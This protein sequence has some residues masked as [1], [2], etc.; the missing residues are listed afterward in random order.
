MK[1][2][3]ISLLNSAIFLTYSVG[4]YYIVNQT[5][6]HNPGSLTKLVYSVIL[7]LPVIWLI[8]FNFSTFVS[9][10]ATPMWYI[11]MILGVACFLFG[12]FLLMS[13]L[14][15][16][17]TVTVGRGI[18]VIAISILVLSILYDMFRYIGINVDVRSNKRNLLL[19]IIKLVFYIPCIFRGILHFIHNEIEIT[20]RPILTVFVL[21][22]CLLLVII[23]YTALLREIVIHPSEGG[24]I[25]VNEPVYLNQQI[26]RSLSS[27][28]KKIKVD[29]SSALSYPLRFSVSCWVFMNHHGSNYLAYAKDS[30]IFRLGKTSSQKRSVPGLFFRNMDATGDLGSIGS[31]V[32]KYDGSAKGSIGEI[33]LQVPL[34]RWT[35]FVF[36]YSDINVFDLFVDG[37]LVESR[38]IS[39]P[40]VFDDFDNFVVGESNGLDGS[41]CN[42]I[43]SPYALS[44]RNIQTQ[45]ALLKDE[46]P[47][48]TQ[49]SK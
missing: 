43:Y 24:I 45:Y 5:L 12:I 19:L 9:L 8:Y 26:I 47:P 38:Q 23:Y 31:Y 25:V 3:L 35:H 32:I 34:S 7:M 44:L 29:P 2:G 36:N 41:I 33:K 48:V 4:S 28:S 6:T 1:G 16:I 49:I 21:E 30:P 17:I 40:L 37:K 22:L 42:L 39:T 11:G 18:V 27:V 46:H 13:T 20:T 15:N 14:N 10:N